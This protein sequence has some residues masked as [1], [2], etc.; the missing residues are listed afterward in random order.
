M[1]TGGIVRSQRGTAIADSAERSRA[2]V[3]YAYRSLTRAELG[4]L[5]AFARS[6]AGQWYYETIWKSAHATLL[7]LADEAHAEIAAEVDARAAEAQSP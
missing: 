6:E 2:A 4:E 5:L 7:Q 3:L 1:I